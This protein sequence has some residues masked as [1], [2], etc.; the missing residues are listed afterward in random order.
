MNK[1]LVFLAAAALAFTASAADKPSAPSSAD[2]AA[3]KAAPAL[4][5]IQ[6]LTIP[7]DAKPGENGTFKYTGKDGKKWIYSTTPF[8]VSRVEDMGPAPE[9]YAVP[10][11]SK[12]IDLGDTVRFE[13]PGPF[14]I[15][16]WEKKK[17]ELT[18]EERQVLDKQN[19]DKQKAEQK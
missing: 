4:K 12:A 13:Q 14:G 15:I 16:R 1:L 3:K 19:S 7:K 11:A 5:T 17:S 2:T 9:S 10:V 8:G 6:P 18:G